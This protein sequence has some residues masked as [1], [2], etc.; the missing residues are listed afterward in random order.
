LI[1][2]NIGTASGKVSRILGQ[3]ETWYEEFGDLLARCGI[4]ASIA[5]ASIVT[6][7]G[8][9]TLEEVKAA[10]ESAESNISL[11]LKEARA[12]RELWERIQKWQDRVLL[13]APKRSKRV[14]K[15]KR[16]EA[17]YTV[18]D[19][20]SLID[21]SSALPIKTD[22]DTARMSQQLHKVHEWRLQARREL[23]D[24]ATSFRALRQAVISDYG[25]PDEFYDEKTREKEEVQDTGAE[26]S[27][28]S[29][30][31]HPVAE[32][33]KQTHDE[34]QRSN[35]S[36]S[37]MSA[38]GTDGARESAE[39]SSQADASSQADSEVDMEGGGSAVCKMISS[40][41][42]GAKLTG[43][44]TSEEEM[45]ELLDKTAKWILRS[46]KCIDS[47][48]DVYERKSFRLFDEF[49]ATGDELLVYRD[50]LQGLK[51]D[52][53]ELL[54]S[55]CSSSGDLISDQL[56]RLKI[57]QAH[58][59]K[60]IAWIKNAQQVLSSKENKATLEVLNELAE[61]SHDYPASK[62][63][64]EIGDALCF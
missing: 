63:L 8:F 49:V 56:V 58:R 22:E 11:D 40:L 30:D 44:R 60:F 31:S 26:V 54:Q 19:L 64:V 28:Q 25:L 59:D 50:S 9:A 57:L 47:P 2:A 24:I 45:T 18:D 52:D 13:A 23:G 1:H 48:K 10:V 51:L 36:S 46:L 7:T 29:Q 53:A 4:T 55:L 39:D 20:I 5:A 32:V 37:A 16:E 34:T 43:V 35:E 62:F 6:P 12:L 41:L 15:G 33:A 3:A 17:R 61:Q 27:E 38:D 21:E 14:G 42:K